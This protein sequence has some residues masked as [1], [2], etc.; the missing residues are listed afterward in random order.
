[1]TTSFTK[2]DPTQVRI[3]WHC[4]CFN[5]RRAS[6]AVTEYYDGVM[7]PSGVKATQFTM[8]GAVAL[9]GPASVTR[10]AEHLA[11]DRTTL[12]RNLKVLAQQGLVSI[13]AGEDRRERV[14]RLT[15]EGQAAIDRAMPLW[16]EAQSAL[17]DK[18]GEDRWRRMIEDMA[19]LG[20]LL[21]E[22]QH[23]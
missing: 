9:M 22:A 2:N 20:A 11:L 6:R 14:V 19:E 1:M 5:V 10:L 13:S 7:A 4:T 23:T 16:H 18:F 21:D 3:A 17:V 8:L 15:D 12:T